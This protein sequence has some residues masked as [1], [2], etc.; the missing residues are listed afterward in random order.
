MAHVFAV[1]FVQPVELYE[2]RG[3]QLKEFC[4]FSITVMLVELWVCR[5]INK[6]VSYQGGS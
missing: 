2:F 6:F 1:M 3:T 4:K 5:G